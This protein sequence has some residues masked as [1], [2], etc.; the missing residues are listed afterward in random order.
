MVLDDSEQIR[1]TLQGFVSMLTEISPVCD[2]T[3]LREQLSEADGRVAAM[4]LSFV[5]P[6]SQMEHAAAVRSVFFLS[7]LLL[8]FLSFSLLL[9]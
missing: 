4:Q 6:L 5:T 8:S 1:M 3:V 9:R 7:T 2:I